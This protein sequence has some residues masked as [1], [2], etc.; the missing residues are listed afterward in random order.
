MDN[1]LPWNREE[2]RFHQDY[3]STQLESQNF[4]WVFPF[5]LTSAL[6]ATAS[7]FLWQ[8]G[9]FHT[10]WHRRLVLQLLLLFY[11]LGKSHGLHYRIQGTFQR[12]MRQKLPVQDCRAAPQEQRETWENMTEPR[13]SRRN[14]GIQIESHYIDF[15][16]SPWHSLCV[17]VCTFVYVYIFCIGQ[18]STLGI[19]L[20]HSSPYF[21][22]FKFRLL[23]Y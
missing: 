2:N 1:E 5:I 15:Y 4:C 10:Q 16:V 11:K 23:F 18:R 7:H 6:L 22:F 19:L 21:F 8:S 12:G 20:N 17:C 14:V 3:C 13:E 9:C